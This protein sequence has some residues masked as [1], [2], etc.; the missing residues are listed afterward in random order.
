MATLLNSNFGPER[1]ETKL[2][3]GTWFLCWRGSRILHRIIVQ[4]A[5]ATAVPGVWTRCILTLSSI[6][7][8]LPPHCWI[9]TCT[10]WTCTRCAWPLCGPPVA[11][12]LL[13]SVWHGP[14]PDQ[15]QHGECADVHGCTYLPLLLCLC[16]EPGGGGGTCLLVEGRGSRRGVFG[17][18]TGPSS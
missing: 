1:L 7:C 3:F 2:D 6:F 9:E 16:K 14:S 10:S 12:R 11:V 4:I 13:W 17:P 8:E 15:H 18:P 5:A